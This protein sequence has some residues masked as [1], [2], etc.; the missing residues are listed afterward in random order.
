MTDKVNPSAPDNE[1][2]AEPFDQTNGVVPGIDGDSDG[3]E[4]SDHASAADRDAADEGFDSDVVDDY[5][6]E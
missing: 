5:R 6:Q 3:S 2:I 4:A 1:S